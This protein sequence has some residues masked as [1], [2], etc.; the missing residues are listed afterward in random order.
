MVLRFLKGSKYVHYKFTDACIEVVDV[1]EHDDHYMI[2]AMWRCQRTDRI[3]FDGT[4]K[5]SVPKNLM[6]EWDSWP[7]LK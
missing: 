4:Q 6:R 7:K 3:Y 2:E 5:F 1:V